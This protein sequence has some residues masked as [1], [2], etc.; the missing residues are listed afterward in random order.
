[1]ASPRVY[2]AAPAAGVIPII[3]NQLAPFSFGVPY[4][5]LAP[6]YLA[7]RIN[8]R[9][10]ETTVVPGWSFVS[11]TW[12]G[13]VTEILIK[14]DSDTSPTAAEVVRK[15]YVI[16]S[17]NLT[18]DYYL[19]ATELDINTGSVLPE[20]MT[21]V[22]GDFRSMRYSSVNGNT[23]RDQPYAYL[24]TSTGVGK[25]AE[26]K[27]NHDPSWPRRRGLLTDAPFLKVLCIGQPSET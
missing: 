10:V 5:F 20:V 19:P 2:T 26:N 14:R 22:T 23:F 1:M 7:F 18:G 15:G 17:F 16:N 21:E 24:C 12:D 6:N 13:S 3:D 11:R 9:F 4:Y 25:E 8:S 27:R